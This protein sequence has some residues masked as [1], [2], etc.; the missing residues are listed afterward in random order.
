M[1]G[2]LNNPVTSEMP[3]TIIQ[4]TVVGKHKA[5]ARQKHHFVLEVDCF[6]AMLGDIQTIYCVRSFTLQG[7]W[8]AGA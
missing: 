3:Y 6:T 1:C 8:A 4:F 2:S 5:V 7:F